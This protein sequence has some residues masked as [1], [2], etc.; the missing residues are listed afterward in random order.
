MSIQTHVLSSVQFSTSCSSKSKFV[1]LVL[2][3]PSPLFVD[4]LHVPVGLE[5]VITIMNTHLA[6]TIGIL[7][8]IVHCNLI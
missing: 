8:T 3:K 6:Q 1:P 7:L 5:I 2:Y 4:E